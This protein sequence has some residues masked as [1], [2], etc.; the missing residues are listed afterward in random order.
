MA[1]FRKRIPGQSRGSE[2]F[3][4]NNPE[5]RSKAAGL[6]KKLKGRYKGILQYDITKN[7]A[8]VWY[9]VDRKENLVM[10]KYAG[11]HPDKY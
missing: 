5:D 4:R 3:L 9:R 8:R 10:I 2:E 7:D 1:C 6:L 11:N